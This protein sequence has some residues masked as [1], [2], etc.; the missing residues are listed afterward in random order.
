MQFQIF[1]LFSLIALA[2]ALPAGPTPPIERCTKDD[3]GKICNAGEINGFY[4]TGQCTDQL[5][6]NDQYVCFPGG[7]LFGTTPAPNN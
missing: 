7:T 3:V 2:A 1:S 4:V 5:F 6:V